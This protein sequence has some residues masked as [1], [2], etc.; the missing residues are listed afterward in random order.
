VEGRAAT[1]VRKSLTGREVDIPPVGAQLGPTDLLG[2]QHAALE[3]GLKLDDQVTFAAVIPDAGAVPLL[4]TA[5]FG[6]ERMNLQPGS[7]TRQK[8]RLQRMTGGGKPNWLTWEFGRASREI[9]PPG[10]E[11]LFGVVSTDDKFKLV[12]CCCFIRLSLNILVGKYSSWH[13]ASNSHNIIFNSSENVT[14]KNPFVITLH[15][16]SYLYSTLVFGEN[17]RYVRESRQY[18]LGFSNT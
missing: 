6:V 15:P 1:H 7:F 12:L 16:F 17:S 11:L 8:R 3:L 4:E 5:C 10:V 9:T 14:L 2:H 18:S 13:F